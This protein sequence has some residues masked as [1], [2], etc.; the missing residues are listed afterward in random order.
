MA[1]PFRILVVCTANVCRSPLAE[2]LLA[3]YFS[4]ARQEG[5][6]KRDQIVLRSEGS[7]AEPG[8]P[9]CP[10]ASRWFGVNPNL[11][12]SRALSLPSVRTSQLI[13]GLSRTHRAACA[14]LDP[15]CRPRL[16][17]L[18][19]AAALSNSVARLVAEE[20]LP[21]GAPNLPPAGFE[22][23]VWLVTEMDAARGTL[24]EATA[25]NDEIADEHGA[26]DHSA[27]FEAVQSASWRLAKSMITVLNA[28]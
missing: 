2:R 6:L 20:T 4:E 19:Q 3:A 12:H 17:T 23:L 27:T 8:Q 21:E 9:M 26:W 25:L 16:F 11:H 22:R 13:V 18:L 10:E 5:R 14:R 1:Q 15:A 24:D 7:D 28:P